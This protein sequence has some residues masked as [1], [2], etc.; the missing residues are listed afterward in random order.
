MQKVCLLAFAHLL[1]RGP[2]LVL[3]RSNHWSVNVQA[4]QQSAAAISAVEPPGS[5][6]GPCVAP[7]PPPRSARA[8]LYYEPPA[9]GEEQE[10]DE[11]ICTILTEMCRT[12]KTGWVR[13]SQL[14]TPGWQMLRTY[15]PPT[16]L[17]KFIREHEQ[18]QIKEI[19]PTVWSFR[20][21]S[22]IRA[23]GSGLHAPASGSERGDQS[24]GA[25]EDVSTSSIDIAEFN[26]FLAQGSD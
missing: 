8:L 25:P 15:V 12:S 2:T 7:A 21:A 18:F 3:L 22:D 23:Q 6:S 4:I 19:S 9:A 14:V 1:L 20:L 10:R 16:G 26:A 11:L 24:S 13:P 5:A 17:A